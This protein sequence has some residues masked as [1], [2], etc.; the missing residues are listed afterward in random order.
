MHVLQYSKAGNTGG[1]GHNEFTNDYVQGL[2]K[3]DISTP[4]DDQLQQNN[5][6]TNHAKKKVIIHNLWQQEIK[7][8]REVKGPSVEISS[9]VIKNGKKMILKVLEATHL[10]EGTL[11]HFNPG[12]LLSS[13]RMAKD[14]ITYFGKHNDVFLLFMK[15]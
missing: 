9:D 4:Y 14:G 15:E 10:K 2:I 3:E 1:Q 12:G 11:L 6:L 13:E 7:Q 5:E 8:T